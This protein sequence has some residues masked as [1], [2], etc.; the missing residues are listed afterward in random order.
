MAIDLA[1]KESVCPFHEGTAGIREDDEFIF[2]LAKSAVLQVLP[3]S[4]ELT[5][6]HG[7]KEISFETPGQIAFAQGLAKQ[8]RFR[9][10]DALGWTDLAW[11]EIA[12]MIEDLA[13]ARVLVRA[14]EDDGDAAI[15]REE[16]PSPLP[17]A[18]AD[19]PRSWREPGLMRELTGRDLDRG[20][21]E[22]VVP[23]FRVAHPC[24]D[25]EGRQVGE[26]NV[27]PKAL[28]LDVPTQWRTCTYGGTRYQPDRPMNVAALKAM[29]THWPEMM[30]V[31]REMR[32]AYFRRFPD[33]AAGWTVG[34]AERLA[35]LVLAL[36]SYLA[37][38][39]AGATPAALHP[40]L[41]NVFRVTDGLRMA[42]HQMMFV[43]FAEAMLDATAPVSAAEIFAYAERNY[44]FHSEHGVCAG[45]QFMIEEFLAVLI[46]GAA[47][48]AGWPATVDP[49]VA[50]ALESIE[51]AID[52][53]LLG[54][55][56]FAASFS[57][58]P[59]MARA[60]A[61]IAEAL[62]QDAVA[63]GAVVSAFEE[64]RR[65]MTAHS[66]LGD[67]SR[68]RHRETVYAQ[69]WSSCSSA[70]RAARPRPA[71][72][73][74]RETPD[75]RAESARRI[76][77]LIEDRVGSQAAAAV[78]AAIAAFLARGQAIVRA[79][80]ANQSEINRLLG[81]PAPRH[82]LTLHDLDLHMQLIGGQARSLPF[83]PDELNRLFGLAIDAD[84]TGI[85][86]ARSADQQF[87]GAPPIEAR[88]AY[89]VPTS[90]D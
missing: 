51:P 65:R 28:R 34:H 52:Y 50:Q 36:P 73:A 26:G 46:E 22:A 84:A 67:E 88:H 10:G 39:E 40:V 63:D 76:H 83:L 48:K 71:F 54:L 77:A 55:K 31:L 19:R 89:R 49:D 60:Y 16:H 29:R 32:A 44:S 72:L 38:R 8:R 56:S 18:I 2:R 1:M 82:A 75:A 11:P 4:S 27:F 6:F 3:G 17:P 15:E 12:S 37:M 70:V 80:E 41:S 59:A 69:L 21:I 25:G 58:W 23:I 53:G 79:A 5:L 86:I 90:G 66:Y 61:Q 30:L 13:G 64:H 42:L 7:D 87:D 20:Y 9:A 43:P 62:A 57:L 68:R 33:A 81:R 24:L 45:P 14:D 35:T 74:E 85:H 78:A 47:P